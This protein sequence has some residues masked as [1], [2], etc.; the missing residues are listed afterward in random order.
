MLT[1][2]EKPSPRAA[3]FK[4]VCCKYTIFSTTEIIIGPIEM[5]PS[6]SDITCASCLNAATKPLIIGYSSRKRLS[7]AVIPLNAANDR[8]KRVRSFSEG[9]L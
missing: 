1:D 9:F 4:A 7:C 6:L 2:S 3:R 5:K 8:M